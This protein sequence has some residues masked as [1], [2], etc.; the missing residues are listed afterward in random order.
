MHRR[1][2]VL[3]GSFALALIPGIVAAQTAAPKPRTGV[4]AAP[5]TTNGPRPAPK[6]RVAA[7][8]P[9]PEAPA[10]TPQQLVRQNVAP[11]TLQTVQ[12]YYLP[13]QVYRD[14]RVFADFGTGRGYQQVTRQCPAYTGTMPSNYA[15][16]ACYLIDINGRYRV[17]HQR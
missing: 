4:I 2:T 10:P 16:T 6:P 5:K 8:A 1:T 15:T 12:V 13:V 7:I 14:G 17:L 11:Q 9:P 3:L